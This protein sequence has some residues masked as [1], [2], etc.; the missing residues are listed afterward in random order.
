MLSYSRRGKVCGK[1]R[2]VGEIY[3]FL[4]MEWEGREEK[5]GKGL[6]SSAHPQG[7]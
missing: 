4:G 6:G 3:V 5:G 7:K 1:H 2:C